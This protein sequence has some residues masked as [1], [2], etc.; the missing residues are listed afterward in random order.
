MSLSPFITPA[1]DDQ[2]IHRA[3]CRHPLL[4]HTAGF[5]PI[6]LTSHS[7]HS[8]IPLRVVHDVSKIVRAGFTDSAF[9][10]SASRLQLTYGRRSILLTMSTD[11]LRN[12]PGYFSGLSSPSVVL[13]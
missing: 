7:H 2:S 5:I 1:G 11:A 6:S 9:A 10:L 4:P 12:I 3:L 13:A 8:A